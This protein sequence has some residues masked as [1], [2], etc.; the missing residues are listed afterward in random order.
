MKEVVTL[1]DIKGWRKGIW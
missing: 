1:N